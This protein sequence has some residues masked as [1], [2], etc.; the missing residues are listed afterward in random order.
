M[1]HLLFPTPVRTQTCTNE[2]ASEVE[3]KRIL[4]LVKVFSFFFLPLYM[5][6]SIPSTTST[7][8]PHH[9]DARH[10]I[11]PAPFEPIQ[12][13]PKY[14]YQITLNQTMLGQVYGTREE[15]YAQ[16]QELLTRRYQCPVLFPSKDATSSPTL[17]AND[18]NNS[19]SENITNN[20]A[21]S[22]R[23]ED[24][25]DTLQNT[26]SLPSPIHTLLNTPGT[27]SSIPPL[28]AEAALPIP[29]TF[30]TNQG[31][32]NNNMLRIELIPLVTTVSAQTSIP[33]VN[34]SVPTINVATHSSLSHPVMDAEGGN[35]GSVHVAN[36]TPSIPPLCQAFT[37]WRIDRVDKGWF[38]S[39]PTETRSCMG[40]LRIHA[41][42]PPRDHITDMLT[43]LIRKVQTMERDMHQH[44]QFH[45]TR[46][47][48]QSC[49]HPASNNVASVVGAAHCPDTAGSIPS[50]EH[51]DATPTVLRIHI[52]DK[53]ENTASNTQSAATHRRD[54][55]TEGPSCPPAPPAWFD[56]SLTLCTKREQH[57]GITTDAGTIALPPIIKKCSSAT[58]T[59]PR[60][61]HSMQFDD[62][63]KEM[64][65]YFDKKKK[66]NNPDE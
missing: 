40:T 27:L 29:H 56:P 42:A 25:C 17:S 12:Y 6:A 15:S 41:S 18:N 43:F 11:L 7:P 1:T 28:P 10:L 34:G 31:N 47:L 30:T 63:F 57:G 35:T 20:H 9:P 59:T 45:Q 13:V 8:I 50:S 5:S 55:V 64:R 66:K 49:H 33:F 26:A 2:H 39:I 22:V 60:V 54:V 46:L 61:R 38:R 14:Y 19:A 23:E 24:P 16:I 36:N 65:A 51:A 4:H 3:R 32:S 37:M 53:T 44:Y 21:S 58:S 52:I 48:Q 62:L